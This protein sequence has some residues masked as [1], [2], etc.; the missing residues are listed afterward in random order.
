ISLGAGRWRIVRQMVME[1][2]PISLLGGGLGILLALWGIDLL[3]AVLPSSLPRFNPI[4]VNGRVLGFT[5]GVAL[6]TLI[7][8]GLAPA[9]QAVK[10]DVQIALNEGGRSGAGGGRQGRLRRLLVVVEVGVALVLLVCAGL[11]V[12]SFIKLK[13]V[14]VGFTA[15]NVLTM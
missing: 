6:F 5:M 12:R 14:D 15:R 2:L 7:L 11:M 4:A 13:Q 10:A 9:L 8:A 1:C 3:S